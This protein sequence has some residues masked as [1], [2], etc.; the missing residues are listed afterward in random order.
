MVRTTVGTAVQPA[1]LVTAP[2]RGARVP[3]AWRLLARLAAARSAARTRA[4][5]R[6]DRDLSLPLSAWVPRLR[7]ASSR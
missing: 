4:S 1:A 5:G 7:G 3:R 2:V 6:R